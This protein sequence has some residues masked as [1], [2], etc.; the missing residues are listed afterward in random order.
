[1][2]PA[3]LVDDLAVWPRWRVRLSLCEVTALAVLCLV[4]QLLAMRGGGGAGSVGLA[5]LPFVSSS[6]WWWQRVAPV[7]RQRLFVSRPR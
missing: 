5:F 2:A 7:A 4:F 6:Q 3:G 1:M